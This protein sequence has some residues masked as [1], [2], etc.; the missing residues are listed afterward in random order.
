MEKEVSYNIEDGFLDIPE[1]EFFGQVHTS[2]NG[3]FVLGWVS[4]QVGPDKWS[5]KVLVIEHGVRIKIMDLKA[6]GE[7]KISNIG[8]FIITSYYPRERLTCV[9]NAYS[10]D[11]L[12][13][14]SK[15]VRALSFDNAI[16]PSG[17]YA[18]WQTANNPDSDDGNKLFFFDLVEKRLVWAIPPDPGWAD[19]FGFDDEKRILRLIYRTGRSY[20]YDYSG[21]FLDADVL[22]KDRLTS[23]LSYEVLWAVEGKLKSGTITPADYPELIDY[24]EAALRK[25][26]EPDTKSLILRRLGEM[27]YELGELS[28]AKE[29]LEEALRLNPKVGAKRLLAK[30]NKELK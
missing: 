15:R 29:G 30:I 24:L 14:L 25:G 22:E 6:P 18:V 2:D 5:D 9:L 19:E 20:R 12:P 7:G 21:E 23:D 16:S 10:S 26:P 27:R 3:R 11:C 8:K 4:F 28:L 13:I 17:N 1:L